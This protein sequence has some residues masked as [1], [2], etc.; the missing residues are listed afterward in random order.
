MSEGGRTGS[1]LVCLLE[2]EKSQLPRAECCAQCQ[3]LKVVDLV[4]LEVTAESKGF[5]SAEK[6]LR[7]EFVGSRTDCRRDPTDAGVRWKVIFDEHHYVARI[8]RVGFLRPYHILSLLLDTL[9]TPC[10]R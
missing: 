5:C 4:A 1:N 9:S 2:M 10:S 6:C 8:E 3:A 7:K